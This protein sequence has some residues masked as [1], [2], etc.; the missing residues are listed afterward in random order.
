[1]PTAHSGFFVFALADCGMVIARMPSFRCG[2]LP[3]WLRSLL[4]TRPA[5]GVML[6]CSAELVIV[7]L[8]VLPTERLLFSSRSEKAQ[9]ST[10][11]DLIS[12]DLLRTGG[13]P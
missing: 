12:R 2:R 3:S 10:A 5:L 8:L 9:I 13:L 4:L 11:V 7:E 6:P 1:M